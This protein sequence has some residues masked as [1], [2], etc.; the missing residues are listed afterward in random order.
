MSARRG[1]ACGTAWPVR[2]VT[3]SFGWLALG[4]TS[5]FVD[6]PSRARVVVGNWKLSL[7][8]AAWHEGKSETGGRIWAFAI[9]PPGAGEAGAPD[10]P[11]LS[12]DVRLAVA[13]E[14]KVP[15]I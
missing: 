11:A 7:A 14:V 15:T 2:Q 13:D 8:P 12:V 10:L 3:V 9:L 1:G 4:L 6:W 5:C